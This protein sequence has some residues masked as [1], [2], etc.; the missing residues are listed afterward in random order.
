MSKMGT[1]KPRD[2]C[3]VLHFLKM[4]MLFELAKPSIESGVQ[5]VRKISALA[6]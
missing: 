3:H 6:K 5:Q 1:L 2:E 4:G